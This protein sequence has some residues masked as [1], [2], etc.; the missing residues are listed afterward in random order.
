MAATRDYYD[1]LGVERGSSEADIKRAYRKLALKYHPDRNK[2]DP[3][4]DG[5]FKEVSEAYEVLSDTEKRRVYDQYGH[6]G[7]KGR[8]FGTSGVDPMDIF[9]SIF[10]GRA[11]GGGG[12]IFEQFFGGGG[13]GRTAARQGSH[14]R[15]SVRISL[16]EAFSGVERTIGLKRNESCTTC[17]GSG[18]RKGTTPER[19]ARCAGRG[20]VGVQQAFFMMQTTCPDCR[21]AGE[22]VRDPCPD[23][24][25]RGSVPAKRDITIKVPAGV[26]D[27]SQLRLSGEGEPGDQGGPRG[28]LFC[29]IEVDDHELFERDGDD[30]LCEVPISF[31]QAALGAD[32]EVPTL[33]GR[34][35]LSIPSGSQSGKVFRLSGKGMPSVYGHGK[36]NLHVR[37]Q[38]ET[39][40][41]LDARQRELLEEFAEIENKAVGTRRKS[42]FEKVR[43]LFE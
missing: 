3:S 29:V 23:C 32:I 2:D 4:A 19:C 14:L 15:I 35:E 21:G 10:G 42:F 38:I 24:R 7:L 41:K 11:G 25:G 18:A 22:V 13:G 40:R 36:G 6:D 37:I 26:H 1:T 27:G 33:S 9:E 30:L 5:K 12:G 16:A 31:A 20:R 28:D 43:D 34:A 17:R 39:P 8:G